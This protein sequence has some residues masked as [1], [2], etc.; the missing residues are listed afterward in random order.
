MRGQICA[1]Y[2]NR[3]SNPTAINFVQNK[4]NKQLTGIKYMKSAK[5]WTNVTNY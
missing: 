3:L 1:I 4:E 5:I 2:Q